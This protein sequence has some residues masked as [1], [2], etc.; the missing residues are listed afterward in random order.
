MSD[1]FLDHI[2]G[3]EREKIRKRMRSP[4]AYERLR[5]K[6]KGPEDL[7]KEL[8]AA[9]KMAEL[10]FA[11]ETEPHTKEKMKASIEADLKEKGIDALVDGYENLPHGVVQMLLEG[12]FSVA[13]SSH[14]TTHE[15]SLVLVPEGNVHEKIPLKQKLVNAYA[16]AV[17]RKKD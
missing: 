9:E 5:E 3:P 14:P 17:L 13:V 10:A 6:V 8:D 16:G 11:L 12:K 7:E 2:P 4:E 15:D 1:A